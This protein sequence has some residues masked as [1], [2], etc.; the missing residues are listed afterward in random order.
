MCQVSNKLKL[1]TCTSDFDKLKHYWIFYKF[2][3]E[4]ND[5][6]IGQSLFPEYFILRNHPDNEVILEKLLN[7]GNAFD[8]AN[9]PNSKDRL[10]LSFTCNDYSEN[11]MTYGFEYIKDKWVAK[12]FDYFEWMSNHTEKSFGKIKNALKK[13]LIVRFLS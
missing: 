4:K 6:L 9:V 7:E 8:I 12:K 5:I 3:K 10:E 13:I 11:R 1:C 2:I